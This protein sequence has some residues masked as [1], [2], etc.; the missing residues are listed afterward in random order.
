M[1]RL[2]LARLGTT[3]PT[4][5]DLSR[6]R[7]IHLSR[8]PKGQIAVAEMILRWDYL[9][10]RPTRIV[11]DGVENIPRDRTVFFAMNHTDRY[12]YWPFQ[13]AMYCKRNLRY[14]ATWVKGKYY[15]KEWIGR[16]M[17]ST[18]NIPLPSRGYLITTEF[19]R[20]NARVPS[21]HEYRILRDVAD[22]K[23]DESEARRNES[24]EVVRALDLTGSGHGTFGTRLEN[25]FQE[26]MDE[27]TRITG[28]AL[29]DE[30]LNVLVFPQGTR[31]KRLPNGHTGLVQVAQHFG[32]S[33]VPV[34]SNGSDRCYPGSAPF[35]RGGRIVYRIGRPLDP[36]GPELGKHRIREAFV[37]FS[38]AAGERHGAAFQTLTDTVMDRINDL[39]DPEYQ[40]AEGKRSD[41]VAEVQRFV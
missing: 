22:G 33:I 2:A 37:P 18:N 16:F 39:L 11:L 35:S 17:D 5:L 10:P 28:E 20:I 36:D 6:L 40:Y 13:Y 14:T 8:V 21:K 27:V 38:R 19:R 12:N 31:S 3:L 23:M 30:D 25:L 1:T 15:E 26:M 9:L 29:R 41:G 34:G 7:R 24:T 32:A 4:V